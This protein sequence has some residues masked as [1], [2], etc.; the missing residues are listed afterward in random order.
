MNTDA[1]SKLHLLKC[2]VDLT[3]MSIPCENFADLYGSNLLFLKGGLEF[4]LIAPDRAAELYNL[5]AP[6]KLIKRSSLGFVI[7]NSE[8]Y[9]ADGN[10]QVLGLN[11][12]NYATK[13][14]S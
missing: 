3:Q 6:E 14:F 9:R 5:S 13:A 11:Y 10:S 7:E 2:K 12:W 8:A 4:I 1:D